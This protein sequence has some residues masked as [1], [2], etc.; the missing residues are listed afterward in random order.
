M[1]D[2]LFIASGRLFARFHQWAAA[3][4][5]FSLAKHPD[6]T[7]RLRLSYTCILGRQS[8]HVQRAYLRILRRVSGRGATAQADEHLW[9]AYLAWC[10]GRLPLAALL[11]RRTARRFPAIAA[12]AQRESAFAEAIISGSLRVA[13]SNAVDALNLPSGEPVTLV[14]ISTRYRDLYRI[15]RQQADRHSSGI[16]V[17]L[18]MDTGP[19]AFLPSPAHIID[20]SPW[21]GFN[22]AGTVDDYS[23]RHLWILRVFTLRELI[24]R[25]HPILSLDLDAI[26]LGDVTAMLNEFAAADIVIQQDHSIPVDVARQLGFVLCCGFFYL[27]PSAALNTFLDRYAAQTVAELDDQTAINHLLAASPPVHREV[28]PDRMTF[29]TCGLRWL[30]P[31]TSLVSRELNSG[32]VVRHFIQPPHTLDVPAIIA[33]MNLQEEEAIPRDRL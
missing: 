33:A 14:P 2:K 5:A 25:G 18:A 27:R 21:F 20:L 13:L 24:L 9:L 17:H 1:L 31:D 30:C 26:L 3:T 12:T 7:T 6:P 19:A 16:I 10:I 8:P 11:N 32:S 22:A 15:W 23:R 4:V 29:E 28:Q